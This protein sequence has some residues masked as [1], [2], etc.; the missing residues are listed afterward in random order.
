MVII[1][2]IEPKAVHSDIACPHY[3]YSTKEKASTTHMHKLGHT[4]KRPTFKKALGKKALCKK[5]LGKKA[6]GKRA[7]GKKAPI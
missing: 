4:P 7:L 5:A 1:H 6:L 3:T 2:C